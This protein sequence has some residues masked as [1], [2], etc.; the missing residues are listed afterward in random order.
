M[1]N[2]NSV[3]LSRHQ[4]KSEEGIES[5]RNASPGYARLI[6]AEEMRGLPLLTRSLLKKLRSGAPANRDIERGGV[7][8]TG[9]ELYIQVT[10]LQLLERLN[11]L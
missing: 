8:G 11:Y 4:L 7:E 9:S 5:Q 10:H 3:M 6:N 2:E 1:S